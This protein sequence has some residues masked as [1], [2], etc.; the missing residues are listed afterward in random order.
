MGYMW[1]CTSRIEAEYTG[2]WIWMR[3][4][5]VEVA[6]IGGVCMWILILTA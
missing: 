2:G 6:R 5:R 3:T 4:S 1:I